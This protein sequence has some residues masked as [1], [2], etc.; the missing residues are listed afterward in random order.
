MFIC[1]S[2]ARRIRRCSSVSSG[3]AITVVG[4]V[5]RLVSNL[6]LSQDMFR[7]G[8]M[9]P[10]FND[11]TALAIPARPSQD[12]RWLIFDFTEPTISGGCSGDALLEAKMQRILPRVRQNLQLAS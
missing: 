6:G 10:R 11:S 2:K 1:A 5:M 7:S 8:G 3:H 12:Y 9:I 4:I